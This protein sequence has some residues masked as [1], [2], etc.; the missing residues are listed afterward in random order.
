MAAVGAEE[1]EEPEFRRDV[2]LPSRAGRAVE[3]ELIVRGAGA[4]GGLA[5]DVATLLADPDADAA[6][7]VRPIMGGVDILGVPGADDLGVEGLD[8]ES[9]KSSSV[10]AL[11]VVVGASTPSTTIPFGNLL[12][13]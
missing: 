11:S 1:T 10:S 2:P 8:Q 3:E 7:G 13:S 5:A 12:M 4:S 6:D 9:K